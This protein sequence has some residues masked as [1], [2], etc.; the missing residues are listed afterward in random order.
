M[1]TLVIHPQDHT[2]D[3]LKEIYQ[4]KGWTV[5]NHVK[6]HNELAKLMIDH[7][8]IVM[9]G[10]G[11]EFGLF[12]MRG[13]LLVNSKLVYILRDKLVV[14]IWCNADKFIKKYE[15]KGFYTGM[16][17]SEH[18]EAIDFA[19]PVY[20]GSIDQSNKLFAS[21]IAAG[22]DQPGMLQITRSL[23]TLPD[24]KVVEFNFCNLYQNADT[25]EL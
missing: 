15:L 4:Q 7:D 10:H 16:I 8:R 11:C 22:I 9:L 20:S 19:V 1:K 13:H 6:S 25:H 3:F 18:E 5:V 24:N 2:T 12:D 17:I 21:S 14:A 23:Y